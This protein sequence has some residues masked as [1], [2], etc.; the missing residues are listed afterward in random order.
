MKAVVQRVSS[1][2]VTVENEIVAQIKQ[3]LLV[4]LGVNE[5]D[6]EN[7][8]EWFSNKLVNLRVFSD[9]SGKM[10]KSVIDI[11]GEILIVP[12]FTIYGDI[13]KGFRPSFT[14]A[15]NPKLTKPIYEKMI[16]YIKE[17]NLVKIETGIFGA[18]MDVRIN[19]DG[20]V[21]IIIEK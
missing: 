21:T 14:K 6:N 4:L 16:N 5:D 18:M 3:G 19:N 9:E 1:A 13:V 10:N 12:N 15:G 8:I 2:S 20:P 11:N 17:M 7:V